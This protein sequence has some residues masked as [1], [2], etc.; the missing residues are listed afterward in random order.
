MVA[1]KYSWPA[2]RV[3]PAFS[4]SSACPTSWSVSAGPGAQEVRRPGVLALLAAASLIGPAGAVDLV[5]QAAGVERRDDAQVPDVVAGEVLEHGRSS[6][7][8]WTGGADGV[9]DRLHAAVGGHAAVDG[10]LRA[11]DEGGLVADEEEHQRRDLVDGPGAAQ[12]CLGDVGVA[13]G[14]RAEAVIGVSM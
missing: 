7:G 4:A 12:R 5:D 1:R 3:W 11:G 6:Q 9:A 2:V 10:D 13:E 8:G 14:R